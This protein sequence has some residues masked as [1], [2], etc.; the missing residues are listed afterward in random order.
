VEGEMEKHET[1]RDRKS[2]SCEVD[3]DSLDSKTF[4]QLLT[5]LGE[6][7]RARV[8]AILGVDPKNEVQAAEAGRELAT[9]FG[10]GSLEEGTEAA[11]RF[12]GIGKQSPDP[13]PL[14]QGVIDLCE[15]KNSSHR[16]LFSVI[17]ER[18]SEFL[19]VPPPEE[20]RLRGLTREYFE[21]CGMGS[22][23]Y[24][25][26]HVAISGVGLDLTSGLPPL[27]EDPTAATDWL[28]ERM[29]VVPKPMPPGMLEEVKRRALAAIDSNAS[30]HSIPEDKGSRRER[31]SGRGR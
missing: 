18:L 23:F 14:P 5:N 6:G 9:A 28:I 21:A 17:A 31:G 10:E 24:H 2:P 7:Y 30:D 19:N 29:P 3:A 8:A 27:V 4:G 11:M 20:E 12:C 25:G 13:L 15:T 26:L 1:P 22:N 16:K